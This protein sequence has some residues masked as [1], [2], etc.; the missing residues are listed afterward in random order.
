MHTPISPLRCCPLIPLLHLPRSDTCGP[1]AKRAIDPAELVS[2]PQFAAHSRSEC[3]QGLRRQPL[4]ARAERVHGTSRQS[5][6]PTAV[7]QDSLLT[8]S[9]PVPRTAA[10]PR[11]PTGTATL[12]AQAL[13]SRSESQHSCPIGLSSIVVA[14]IPQRPRT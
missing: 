7:R 13:Q 1:G 11:T 8:C 2:D 14:Y 10:Q 3:V 12:S 5:L 9:S 4:H 6:P